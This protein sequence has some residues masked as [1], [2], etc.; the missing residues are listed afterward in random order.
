M[1]DLDVP[2]SPDAYH[3]NYVLAGLSSAQ[4]QYLYHPSAEAHAPLMAAFGWTDS[5]RIPQAGHNEASE[6]LTLTPRLHPIYVIPEGAA[7]KMRSYF[8]TKPLDIRPAETNTTK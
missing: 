5:R 8:E 1:A 3:T 6:K 4:H 2:R 7:E